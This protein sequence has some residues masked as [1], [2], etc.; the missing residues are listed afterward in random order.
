VPLPP[1]RAVSRLRMTSAGSSV[2]LVS[3]VI[4]GDWVVA[5][6]SP[7]VSGKSAGLVGAF[8]SVGP[9]AVAGLAA[10]A[11]GARQSGAGGA[12]LFGALGSALLARHVE[13]AVNASGP[14]VA[15]G[16]SQS[17]ETG[18][19]VRLLRCASLGTWT[20]SVALVS[21]SGAVQLVTATLSSNLSTLTLERAIQLRTRAAHVSVAGVGAGDVVVVSWNATGPARVALVH[22][23]A[24]GA[25]VVSAEAVMPIAA[26]HDVAAVDGNASSAF[27][28]VLILGPA[29]T[30]ASV[31]VGLC[32]GAGGDE[33]HVALALLQWALFTSCMAATALC[34]L[35]AECLRR[36]RAR[37]ADRPLLPA[38]EPEW[39]VQ[40]D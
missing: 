21:A 31:L 30:V 34:L 11:L 39:R 10:C 13:A 37:G 33:G 17:L 3:M 25:A 18:E 23:A 5:G 24:P 2:A 6:V 12:I 1:E 4:G 32:P 15:V 22:V 14:H 40:A 35:A 20:V 9:A 38:A 26:V 28:A 16:A 29:R 8:V 19:D 36:R 7:D 27:G